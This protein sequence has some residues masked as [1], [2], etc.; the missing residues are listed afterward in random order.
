MPPAPRRPS[1]A[2]LV[3]ER[4][5]TK[6]TP[7]APAPWPAVQAMPT[8]A[9]WGG[10]TAGPRSRTLRKRCPAVAAFI[11]VARAPD[12][13]GH[14]GWLRASGTGCAC[15]PCTCAAVLNA[16]PSLAAGGAVLAPCPAYGSSL[17]HS[18]VAA[19]GGAPRFLSLF[20]L[21]GR[22][23]V[24][25]ADYLLR[26][27][28][29]PARSQHRAHAAAHELCRCEG[30]YQRSSRALVCLHGQ[31][32]PP[33]GAWQRCGCSA[34]PMSC[35]ATST[36]CSWCPSPVS[37]PLLCRQRGQQDA[38]EDGAHVLPQ[39]SSHGQACQRA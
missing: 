17:K 21:Q 13:I 5:R 19:Y 10:C 14:P 2:V 18:A 16:R 1:A 37:R 35:A 4:S 26:N 39:P 31:L 7:A 33:L 34:L 9:A 23:A 27:H 38:T 24:H 28:E 8:W 15:Q 6:P 30:I 22:P 11:V 36:Q 20:V 25:A 32:Q 29:R 12:L 3:P